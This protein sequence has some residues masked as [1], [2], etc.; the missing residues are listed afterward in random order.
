MDY[1][2]LLGEI[3]NV[4]TT[5]KAIVAKSIDSTLTLRNWAI[6]AYIIEYEQNGEDRAAYGSKLMAKLA[7][8][9]KKQGIKGLSSRNLK[10]FRQFAITY[11]NIASD[12]IA[13]TLFFTDSTEIRQTV[14]AESEN[15]S[16]QL[17]PSL[18]ERAEQEPRLPWQN[19]E[20]YQRLL[21]SLSWSHLLELTRL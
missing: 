6:G 3:A 15:V 18:Q 17:F 13:P 7:A 4:Q 12:R 16:P 14:S 2:K 1:E 8:D 11:P 21:A 9:F 20:Y 19:E 5:A 10:N